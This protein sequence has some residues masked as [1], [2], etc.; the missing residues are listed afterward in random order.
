MSSPRPGPALERLVFFGWLSRLPFRSYRA[1]VVATALLGACGPLL[2]VVGWAAVGGADAR[3]PLWVVGFVSAVG[4]FVTAFSLYHLLEPVI[5]TAAAFRSFVERRDPSRLPTCYLDD[6]AGRLMADAQRTLEKLGAT[7]E[8]AEYTDPVTGL[9][10][11]RRFEDVVKGALANGEPFAV[12]VIRFANHGELAQ[13]LGRAAADDGL[14]A[15]VGRLMAHGDGAENLAHLGSGALAC[16]LYAGARRDCAEPA[17]RVR[18]AVEGCAGGLSIGSLTLAPKLHGGVARFPQ[19][20]EEAETLVDYA[21]AAA[22]HTGDSVPVKAHSARAQQSAMERFKLQHELRRALEADEFELHYQPII[23]VNE[24]RA[25]GAEALIR[26]RHPDRGL[27]RPAEFV[28]IAEETTLI[29]T[30]HRWVLRRACAQLR[31][32]NQTREER[33]LLAIN[34]SARQFRDPRLSDHVLAAI[35]EFGIGPEQLELELTETAAMADHQ[36]TYNVFARLREAGVRIAIDDFGTG[37]SSMSYLRRLPFD[38]LKIDRE[39]VTG[40]DRIRHNQA[41]CGAIIELCHGLGITVLAEGTEHV[42]EVLFLAER[43]CHLFQGFYFSR[44]LPTLEFQA[45]L[46]RRY[47]LVATPEPLPSRTGH[48]G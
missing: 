48:G 26:W 18:Q 24:L 20:A 8:A 23:D 30:M 44:P 45:S 46:E 29:D 34:L 4:A 10:N 25:V 5:L 32:W 39:F 42:G 47:E 19:D 22:S 3:A 6:E 9:P 33:L 2:V 7:L 28:P 37:Y 1:K 35:D 13:T 11:R 31:D 27:M 12:A 41:I 38:K 36:H 40:V 16:V 43:G 14:R 15:L 21:I 17:D